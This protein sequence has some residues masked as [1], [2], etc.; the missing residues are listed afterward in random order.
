MDK[1]EKYLE[2]EPSE[3]GAE[4][5][6]QECARGLDR[7]AVDRRLMPSKTES[8]RRLLAK[9]AASFHVILKCRQVAG[10][11]KRLDAALVLASEGHSF[12][13]GFGTP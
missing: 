3:C 11:G 10:L 9:W 13:L 2:E 1:L 4:K 12:T 6:W 7:V 5:C 8:K